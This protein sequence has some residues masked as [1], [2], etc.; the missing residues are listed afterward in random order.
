M[1][2]AAFMVRSLIALGVLA[3][4]ASL[5]PAMLYQPK[6]G[7]FSIEIPDTWIKD[8]S[9]IGGQL[10]VFYSSGQG[11]KAFIGVT[12]RQV[13]DKKLQDFADALRRAI[14]AKHDQV[15]SDGKTT[16][17]AN[18]AH[19]FRV[20]AA[21]MINRIILAIHNGKEYEWQFAVKAEDA[22]AFSPVIEQ[23]KN[24][25]N[26]KGPVR[27][28]YE[29]KD[30]SF[31]VDVPPKWSVMDVQGA[32]DRVVLVGPAETRVHTIIRVQMKGL[33]GDSLDQSVNDYLKQAKKGTIV[34][35][36]AF[37]DNEK[38]LLVEAIEKPP[39]S[40]QSLNINGREAR[41]LI[42]KMKDFGV[43]LD[44]MDFTATDRLDLYV[45]QTFI[46][47]NSDAYIISLVASGSGAEAYKT[48]QK[49]T[50]QSMTFAAGQ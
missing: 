29:S 25:L 18:E 23:I 24:S 46:K 41:E 5:A 49:A 21:G 42:F 37:E 30:K 26:W 39:E 32:N 48:L 17:G 34:Q 12:V 19:E 6:N 28:V 10:V 7:A 1:I 35:V 50:V 36:G 40:N 9:G 43:S 13:G 14:N 33:G 44:S 3:G 2:V 38:Y 11:A 20:S 47:V 31:S 8:D 15:L 4:L 22:K 27:R 45:V 16:F